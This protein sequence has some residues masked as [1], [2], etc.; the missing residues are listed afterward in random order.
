MPQKKSDQEKEGRNGNANSPGGKTSDNCKK[1]LSISLPR[2][3]AHVA[4]VGW[5][6]NGKILNE[7]L[8]QKEDPTVK[9]IINA[10]NEADLTPVYNVVS[11]QDAIY[12]SQAVEVILSGPLIKTKDQKDVPVTETTLYTQPYKQSRQTNAPPP[13]PKPSK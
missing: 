9:A 13:P 7:H 5:T 12:G 1:A 4:H 3:F 10:A 6:G 8:L 2:N 11:G